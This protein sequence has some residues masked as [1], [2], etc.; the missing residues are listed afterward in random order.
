[1]GTVIITGASRGIGPGLT[2]EESTAKIVKPV[3][4]HG[5]DEPSAISHTGARRDW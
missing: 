1:M 5:P 3:A 2:V 4:E